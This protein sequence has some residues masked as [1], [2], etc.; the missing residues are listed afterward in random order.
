MALATSALLANRF[1]Q[2]RLYKIA[3]SPPDEPT[4][5]DE[6]E[7]LQKEHVVI[8]DGDSGRYIIRACRD[9]QR[10]ITCFV[11]ITTGLDTRGVIAKLAFDGKKRILTS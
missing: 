3:G 6:L 2:N 7:R 9:S 5:F 8:P 1:D 11:L 4:A 10:E